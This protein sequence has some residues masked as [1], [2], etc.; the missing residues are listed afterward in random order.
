MAQKDE[1]LAKKDGDC[2]EKLAQK[3][4][5]CEEK[6]AKKGEDWLRLLESN[7]LPSLKTSLEE[8]YF[9]NLHKRGNFIDF[10]NNKNQNAHKKFPKTDAANLCSQL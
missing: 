7:D 2:K 4:K 5:D 10:F 6:L 9:I 3:D 8:F 1:P